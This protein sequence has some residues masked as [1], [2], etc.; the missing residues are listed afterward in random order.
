VKLATVPGITRV[1]LRSVADTAAELLAVM[2]R[3]R[4]EV[5]ARD[6]TLGSAA[7]Q[8]AERAHRQGA[9]LVA[10]VEHPVADPAILVGGVVPVPR[11]MDQDTAAELGYYLADAGSPGIRDVTKAHTAL[12][13][14]VVIVERIPV[15]GPP[16]TGVPAGAQLQAVVVD[17]HHPRVA[18]FT[19]HS[20]TGRGWLELATVAGQLVATVD[21]SPSTAV[22]G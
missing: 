1:S 16:H 7:W 8:A 10:V 5:F 2:S 4:G 21:F 19:L 9:G 14:P 20:P 13:Y 15:A 11:P 12:G 22:A 6:P 17:P 3:L 18:V